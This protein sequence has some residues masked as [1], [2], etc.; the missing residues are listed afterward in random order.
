MSLCFRKPLLAVIWNCKQRKSLNFQ[1]CTPICCKP[2]RIC[3]NYH[4]QIMQKRLTNNKYQL[5]NYNYTLPEDNIAQ[6]PSIPHHNAK[7]L[8]CNKQEDTSYAY[9]N[10]IFLDLPDI[11]TENDI[12]FFNN[13]KVFKA[14]LP[15]IH[16][17]VRRHSGYNTTIENGEIMIY[18]LIDDHHFEG[19]VSDDKNFKP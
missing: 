18:K 17:Q 1:L 4:I 11:L 3:L 13:S 10:K 6:V 19:L 7:L 12:L 2:H 16:Q 5:E 8:I 15:L 9:E 14:R